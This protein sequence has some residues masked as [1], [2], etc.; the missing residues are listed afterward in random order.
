MPLTSAIW[1]SNNGENEKLFKYLH[2]NRL[3]KTQTTA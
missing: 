2:G 1:N 3:T